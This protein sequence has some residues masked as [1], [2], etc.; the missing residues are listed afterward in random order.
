MYVISVTLY[1]KISMEIE[2]EKTCNYRTII[3]YEAVY[4]ITHS[5]SITL[6]PSF[7]YSGIQTMPP[8]E[9]D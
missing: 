9:A 8:S 1:A 5:A 3:I 4:I 6:I 2:L 7:P